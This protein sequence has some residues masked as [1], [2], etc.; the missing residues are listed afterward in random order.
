[1]ECSHDIKRSD[2]LQGQ[3]ENR[4]WASGSNDLIK[5]EFGSTIPIKKYD[6]GL[7]GISCGIK[8]N[9]EVRIQITFLDIAVILNKELANI[10]PRPTFLWWNKELIENG[11][12]VSFNGLYVSISRKHQNLSLENL[13][14]GQ[15]VSIIHIFCYIDNNGSHKNPRE[16]RTS[17]HPCYPPMDE[18]IPLMWDVSDDW[19]LVKKDW[20]ILQSLPEELHPRMFKLKTGTE[21]LRFNQPRIGG[22]LVYP[23]EDG[24]PSIDGCIMLL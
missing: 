17:L 22:Q 21:D 20:L 24:D 15:M 8:V 16:F 11:L 7:E 10:R 2:V 14:G 13:S 4:W 12:D 23:R 5:K 18:T 6:R 3:I 9:G 19:Y 1:M